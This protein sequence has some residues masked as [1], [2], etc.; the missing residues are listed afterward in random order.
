MNEFASIFGHVCSRTCDN[1][2]ITLSFNFS[3]ISRLQHHYD[4]DDDADDNDDDDIVVVVVA[5]H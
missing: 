5:L 4:D 1:V 3:Q 2:D